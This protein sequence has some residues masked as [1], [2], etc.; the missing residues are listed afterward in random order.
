MIEQ[1]VSFWWFAIAT[2]LP[3]IAL[4]IAEVLIYFKETYK[5]KY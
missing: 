3:F 5:Q 1:T 4:G 2:F